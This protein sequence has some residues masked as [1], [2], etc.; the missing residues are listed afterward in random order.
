MTDAP[1]DEFSLA[2]LNPTGRF[3]DR[4]ADYVKYRP[5]YP[6]AAFA[7][8]IAGLRKPG[9]LRVADV[10][11]GTGISARGVAD[12]G[13]R[14]IAVEPNADMRAAAAPHRNVEWRD[15]MSEATGLAASSVDLVLCA[16]AFHWFR[17]RESLAEF[18]RVLRP[19]GRLALLWNKRDRRDPATLGYTEAI[20][21]VDGEH[22]AERR[23]FD[24]A[25]VP[26][27]GCFTALHRLAFDHAQALDRAGLLGRATSASYVPKEGA[28]HAELVRRL[29]ALYERHRDARGIVTL[30]Y[31]TELWLAERSDS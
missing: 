15:G 12:L 19:G 25:V 27:S 23:E 29:D 24:P 26:M 2:D 6:A 16:Q 14:V 11:A 5:D 17:P 9:T 21:A 18:H 13:P 28:G 30:R 20:R 1:R 3:S 31:V 10:G 8:A 4:A 7:A 22:P